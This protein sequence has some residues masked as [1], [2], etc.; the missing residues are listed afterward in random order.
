MKHQQFRFN[1]CLKNTHNLSNAYNILD[2]F[3]LVE[4]IALIYTNYM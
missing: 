2:I 1:Q 4:L 3:H